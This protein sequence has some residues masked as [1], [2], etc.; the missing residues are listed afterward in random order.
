[1]SS[2][3]SRRSKARSS[4]LASWSLTPC[5]ESDSSGAHPQRLPKLLKSARAVASLLQSTHRTAQNLFKSQRKY[6]M[7]SGFHRYLLRSALL[8]LFRNCNTDSLLP[9]PPIP[10]RTQTTCSSSGCGLKRQLS[11]F[12]KTSAYPAYCPAA[13]RGIRHR[14]FAGIMAQSA[15]AQSRCASQV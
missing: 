11:S 1:M 13:C 6:G 10:E 4:R 9:T 14:C 8:C 2:Q 5:S 7:V 3:L 15:S 12:C